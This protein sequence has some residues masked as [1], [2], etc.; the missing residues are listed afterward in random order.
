[1]E[2][3]NNIS[4][5]MNYSINS[6]NSNNYNSL[7]TSSSPE[8]F[9]DLMNNGIIV[10]YKSAEFSSEIVEENFKSK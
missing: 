7:P 1:M 2:N 4:E 9:P 10:E 3:K 5:L 6:S 8:S